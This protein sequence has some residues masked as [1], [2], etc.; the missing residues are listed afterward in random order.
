MIRDCACL[1]KA[2]C[3]ECD[4][5]PER[6]LLVDRYLSVEQGIALNDPPTPINNARKMAKGDSVCNEIFAQKIHSF[7]GKG[8]TLSGQVSTLKS[9]GHKEPEGNEKEEETNNALQIDEMITSLK[10]MQDALPDGCL[11]QCVDLAMNSKNALLNL[12]K[13]MWLID[14]QSDQFPAILHQGNPLTL[15]NQLFDQKMN[16]ILDLMKKQVKQEKKMGLQPS[17][18]IKGTLIPKKIADIVITKSGK[19]N[20]GLLKFVQ[21]LFMKEHA[22]TLNYGISLKQ[23]LDQF[24]KSPEL[25]ERF[26]EVRAPENTESRMSTLVRI[27]LGLPKD[28][29]LSDA[30]AKRAAIAAL[31]SHLRQYSQHSCFA[32]FLAI[33]MK[34]GHLM[35]CLDDFISLLENGHLTR[36]VDNQTKHFPFLMKM[37][38]ASLNRRFLLLRNGMAAI[39]KVTVCPIEDNSGLVAACLV[40]GIGDPKNALLDISNQINGMTTPQTVIKRLA[41]WQA[42]RTKTSRYKGKYFHEGCFAFGAQEANPLLKVW[43]NTIAGM[44]EGTAHCFLGTCL[45]KSVLNVIHNFLVKSGFADTKQMTHALIKKLTVSTKYMYDPSVGFFGDDFEGGFVLYEIL[46]TN[47]LKRIDSILLFKEFLKHAFASVERECIDHSPPISLCRD[48]CQTSECI[49]QIVHDYQGHIGAHYGKIS[50]KDNIKPWINIFGHNAQSILDVYFESQQPLHRVAFTSKNG[51]HLMKTILDLGR[52]LQGF[53]K[54]L[55]LENPH[56]MTPARVVNYHAFS[57]LLGHSSLKT[58]WQGALS[59]FKWMKKN[60]LKTGRRLA[61]EPLSQEERTKLTSLLDAGFEDITILN[62]L[63]PKKA[64]KHLLLSVKKNK[65]EFRRIFDTKVIEAFDNGKKKLM[66]QSIIHFADTNLYSGIHDVHFCFCV[67]P[68]SGKVEVWQ[69]NDDNSGL[70]PLDQNDIARNAQWEV[71]LN[72]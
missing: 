66:V 53:E 11:E 54:R 10:T 61:N 46:E 25:R 45:V 57:L 55:L 42:K 34:R 58:A 16:H 41:I 65:A 44:A 6:G 35:S 15:I 2:S 27:S 71:Y 24:L 43:V 37:S 29:P 30:D 49:K 7:E 9:Y 4:D 22:Q 26:S 70:K 32:A 36:E 62:G 64:R 72:I 63:S 33:N 19:I 69:A 68:G 8:G 13:I 60:L 47:R 50:E 1:D 18:M 31:L 21:P 67:N 59:P 12:G 3:F 38:S 28:S 39:D 56:F 20:L 14:H 23:T 48:F 51:Y 40:M 17:E 5:L 52:R